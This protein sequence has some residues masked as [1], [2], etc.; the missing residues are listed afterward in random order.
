MRS[1]AK[2]RAKHLTIRSLRPQELVKLRWM[3]SCERSCPPIEVSVSLSRC[4]LRLSKG[5][6]IRASMGSIFGV[7][8]Q[9]VGFRFGSLSY[10]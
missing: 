6:V 1:E 5:F 4:T 10:R 9:L 3:G 2:G 8:L 7:S